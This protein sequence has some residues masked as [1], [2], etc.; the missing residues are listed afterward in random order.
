MA[1][2]KQLINYCNIEKDVWCLWFK[3]RTIWWRCSIHPRICLIFF[4]F[5]LIICIYSVENTENTICYT[6]S[7]HTHTLFHSIILQ[8]NHLQTNSFVLY[9][10]NKNINTWMWFICREWISQKQSYA[11]NRFVLDYANANKFKKHS[12]CYVQKYLI[13]KMCTFIYLGIVRSHLNNITLMSPFNPKKL[14]Y[15]VYIFYWGDCIIIIT[16]TDLILIV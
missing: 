1:T 16:F 13:V 7:L 15:S 10:A 5:C 2:N 14:I 11:N 4:L 8:C 3:Y 6:Q 9:Y 12:L